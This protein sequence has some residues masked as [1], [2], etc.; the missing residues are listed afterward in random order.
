MAEGPIV[1]ALFRFSRYCCRVLPLSPF[2]MYAH[3]YIC[4]FE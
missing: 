1:L 3:I 2:V 4:V